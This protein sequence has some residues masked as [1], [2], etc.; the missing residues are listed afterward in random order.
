LSLKNPAIKKIALGEVKSVP[1]GQYALEVLNTLKIRDEILSKAVYAKDVR[2]VLTWVET[3]NV[4]AGIVYKTDALISKGKVVIA[5]IAP[6]G[7]HKSVVYPAA[8]VKDC[9]NQK[10]AQDFLSYLTDKKAQAVFAKYGFAKV[11]K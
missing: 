9:K 7:T 8:I 11:T 5:A 6:K 4:D 10:A 1:A 3:G 2:E